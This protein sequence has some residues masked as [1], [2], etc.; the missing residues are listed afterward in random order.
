MLGQPGV[1]ALLMHLDAECEFVF[2]RKGTQGLF[3]GGWYVYVGGA[4]GSGGLKSRTDRHKRR[5]AS[6]KRIHW[7]V[8]FFRE[9]ATICEMW[10]S[11]T[12]SARKEHEWAKSIARMR[13]A[14]VPVAGFGANDCKQGCDAHF[15]HFAERLFV[16]GF[17]T[18]LLPKKHPE[19]LVEFTDVGRLDQDQTMQ[20]G[21]SAPR[22]TI[23]RYSR[24]R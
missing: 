13:G 21:K 7:N 5:P 9:R 6:G 1:Y 20:H 16:T 2:D 18:V 24:A 8:D 22:A 10:F 3:S 14:S 12:R 11:Y 4:R 15:I 17:R 19:V 23:V